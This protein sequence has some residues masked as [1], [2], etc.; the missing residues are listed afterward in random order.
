MHPFG[1]TPKCPRCSKAVYAAEQVMG[2]GRKLYHKPCLTCTSC[3]VRLDSLRL[4]EHEAEPYCKNCHS[5]NFGTRDLRSANLPHQAADPSLSP[6]RATESSSSPP[7][8][9]AVT[10][11]LSRSLTPP[12]T[13]TRKGTL[14]ATPIGRKD[15]GN[16]FGD[17]AN[18]PG[19]LL[20]PTR[21]LSPT[22]PNFVAN[23]EKT[24]TSDHAEEDEVDDLLFTPSHTGRSEGGLP[25][26]VPLVSTPTRADSPTKRPPPA[27]LGRALSVGGNGGTGTR[28]VVPLVANATGTRYGAALAGGL[29]STP[30][31]TRQWGSGT[32]QCPACSKN[33][34]FAE[35]VKAIGKTWHKECLRCSECSTLLDSSRLTEKDGNPLCR[36]CYNK[37]HGPAGS[38][39]ALLGKAGG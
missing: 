7:P 37:L 10:P 24:D 36:R 15:T 27:T 23:A 21:V 14:F 38:G 19:P 3:G 6:S 16:V 33:V 8:R 4:L 2:P 11:P 20:R 9:P 32:P 34:Y 35:Q 31:G 18:S 1:G 12:Q 28:R 29:R 13:S 30:T 25:R 39:Y 5:K 26:T 22:R 17:A